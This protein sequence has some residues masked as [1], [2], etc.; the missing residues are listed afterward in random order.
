MKPKSEK[1]GGDVL[2][3]KSFHLAVR[4]V[5]LYRYLTEE[6]KE[7][8]MSKQLLR[9]GTNPGAMVREAANAESPVDFV[10]KLSVAQKETGETQFWLEL[11]HASD[12]LNEA[13]YQSIYADTE[14]IMKI[15]RSSILTKKQKLNTPKKE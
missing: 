1:P 15:I 10:H 9:S 2:R 7:F 5:R 11:L 12:F 6:K 14:E 3:E 13:E 8:V 4:I